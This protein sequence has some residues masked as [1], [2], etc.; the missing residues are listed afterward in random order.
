M[1]S[2]AQRFRLVGIFCWVP[3]DGIDGDKEIRRAIV[4]N[5]RTKQEY[6]AGEGDL[7]DGV[8]VAK[9]L[10]RSVLLRDGGI[11]EELT[12]SYAGAI[13]GSVASASTTGIVDAAT[14]EKALSANRF[15][16]YVGDGRW[17]MSRDGLLGYVDE[18]KESPARI[19]QL[20]DSMAPLYAAGGGGRR[21]VTGYRLQVV[22]EKEFY[23]A[24][25]LLEG[26]VVRRV[27]TMPVTSK[28]RAMFWID[29]FRA[30]RASAFILDIER[31][32]APMR[33]EYVIR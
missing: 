20:F 25:G 19:S 31:N 24:V 29:E 21:T 13:T 8:L 1:G 4:D 11:E 32:G 5:L 9:V 30:G 23:D 22:G 26:D 12:M 27:N 18:I 16:A 10:D 17:I 2:L 6:V 33:L 7:V 15:G 28:R 14:G 3:P